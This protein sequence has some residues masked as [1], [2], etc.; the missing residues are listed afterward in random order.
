MSTARCARAQRRKLLHAAEATDGRR[1]AADGNRPTEPGQWYPFEQMPDA[2]SQPPSSLV[3]VLPARGWASLREELRDQMG[4]M[5]RG[6]RLAEWSLESSLERA[7]SAAIRHRA[8]A[9][10]V[11]RYQQALDNYVPQGQMPACRLDLLGSM[12]HHGAPTRLLDFT[13]SPYVAA[14]FAVEDVEPNET[15]VIWAI[16]EGACRSLAEG[17]IGQQVWNW[18]YESDDWEPH[19]VVAPAGPVK[20]SER[21]IAQQSLFLFQGNVNRSL[22]DNMRHTFGDQLLDH[23]VCYAIEGKC[24]GEIL[25]DLRLMNITRASLFPGLDGFARSLKYALIEESPEERYMRQAKASLRL[26]G[27]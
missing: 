24:R 27:D 1:A 8:E 11:H 13:R 26:Q 23:V 2:A 6:Q 7:F 19:P 4:W 5:Y 16:N 17:R 9:D 20:L 12:Q 21:Q 14:Y 3:P 15:C 10:L 22:P 25:R 18:V